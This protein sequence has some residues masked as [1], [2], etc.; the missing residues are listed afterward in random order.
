MATTALIVREHAGHR[1]RQRADGYLDATAMCA[2]SGKK[3][4]DYR[5]TDPTE[6]FIQALSHNTGIPALSLVEAKR[7]KN[8]GTWVHPRVGIHLA[9]WCSP[10]L[11]ATA[12]GWIY[13][14]LTTGYAAIKGGSAPPADHRPWSAR[15]T[16][17]FEAHCRFINGRSPG[18]WSVLTATSTPM[19][20]LE[21]CLLEHCLPLTTRDLPDNSVG[22]IWA[23]L[24]RS[25]R[26]LDLQRFAPLDLPGR[27]FPV[28]VLIY[29]PEER[30]AFD[31][32]FH[33][34]YVPR[35]MPDYL[36]RK[37]KTDHGRLP[38][39]SAADQASLRISDR[40]AELEMRDRAG[41]AEIGG[42]VKAVPAIGTDGDAG[43][44]R[45]A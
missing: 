2:A 39:A 24:R 23:D 18:W 26:L 3:W 28:Q 32:F 9:Q 14:L 33:G 44:E 37:F 42:M 15:L 36:L 6:A 13:E 19:M 10:E 4:N 5:R 40:P 29:P 11:A 25:R 30:G 17:S 1:I 45:T 16:R 43:P 22:R 34:T 21:D 31:V 38:P 35:H 27:K 41:L 20:V 7:G 12:T 8:G